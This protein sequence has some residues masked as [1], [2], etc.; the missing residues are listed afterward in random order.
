MSGRGGGVDGPGDGLSEEVEE[1]GDGMERTDATGSG[2]KWA[3]RCLDMLSCMREW[4]WMRGS[5]MRK[6]II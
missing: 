4:L 6:G 5:G 2:L 1:A 3:R